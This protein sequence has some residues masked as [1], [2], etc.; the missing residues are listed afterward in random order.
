[1]ILVY[2]NNSIRVVYIIINIDIMNNICWHKDEQYLNKNKMKN[3]E[4][5]RNGATTSFSDTV[6]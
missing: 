5:N 6:Y 3:K 2:L 1:M 4:S